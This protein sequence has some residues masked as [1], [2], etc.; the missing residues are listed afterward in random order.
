MLGSPPCM[1]L[2]KHLYPSYWFSA[3][4]HCKFAAIVSEK[5]EGERATK[6]LSLDKCL[7]KRK[8]L[9]VLEVHSRENDPIQLS[10]DLEWLTILYLTNHLLSI[11]DSTHYMP[12]Q[13]GSGRW[14]YTPTTKEK[15]TVFEKFNSN[16]NIPLNFTR[17]VKPYDPYDVDIQIE[18][19]RLQINGQTTQ[20][21]QTLGID[22]PSALLQIIASN[23]NNSSR[24]NETS[25]DTSCEYTPDSID[26]SMSFEEE[27]NAPMSSSTFEDN[28]TSR[29]SGNASPAHSLSPKSNNSDD[30]RDDAVMQMSA[31]TLDSSINDSMTFADS[32]LADDSE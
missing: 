14:I 8:F 15:Q 32:T 16:M 29:L 27:D 20:F 2:L 1:E 30:K 17:T 3:H 13:H 31:N 24:S 5:G 25:M 10:Y 19:P 26:I 4:L 12:G 18:Q 23:R 22:D 21:C 11:K 6:F 9:Q 7:P 28:S